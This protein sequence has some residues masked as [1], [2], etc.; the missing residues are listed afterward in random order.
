[1]P[2]TIVVDRAGVVRAAGVRVDRV[3]EIAGKLLAENI[4]APGAG[5]RE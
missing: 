1:M 2:W 3:R 4:N 5:S